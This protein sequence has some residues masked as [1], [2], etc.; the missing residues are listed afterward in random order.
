[1]VS[2]LGRLDAWQQV[3]DSLRHDPR[4]IVD[5]VARGEADDAREAVRTHI[6]GYYIEVAEALRSAGA[7]PDAAPTP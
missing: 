2:S 3:V 7:L 4:K 1:M 5:A 6:A